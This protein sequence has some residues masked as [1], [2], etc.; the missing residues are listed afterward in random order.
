MTAL[1]RTFLGET[2][3]TAN[4]YVY[5]NNSTWGKLSQRVQNGRHGDIVIFAD[6]SKVV[7]YD[8]LASTPGWYVMKDPGL[9][10]VTVAKLVPFFGNNR[11]IKNR[12]K[13]GDILDETTGQ[14][15]SF[16]ANWKI[17]NDKL[18]KV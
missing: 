12:L 9:A 15:I 7:Q 14:P 18:V 16:H 17:E 3:N 8:E 2:L 13:T 11:A 4:V 10:D 5:D 6:T 1:R